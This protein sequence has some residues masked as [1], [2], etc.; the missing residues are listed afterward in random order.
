MSEQ[1][2]NL[3]RRTALQIIVGAG[4]AAAFPVIGEA[5]SAAPACHAASQAAVPAAPYVPRFFN[6]LLMR[7]IAALT[8]TII[9]ADPHSPGAKAAKVNEYIDFIV[10]ETPRPKGKEWTD[11]LNEIDRLAKAQFGKPFADCDT[12]SQI[13]LLESISRNEE[14]PTNLAEG[15]FVTVKR[16]TIDGYYTSEIGIHQ[17]LQYQGNTFLSEFPG[18]THPSH[19]G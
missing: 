1:Q 3:T 7:T 18:C 16:A 13:A 15:F 8:E 5:R 17:D 6:D 4:S 2:D 14:H 10:A 11:G 9:P 19:R 12:S